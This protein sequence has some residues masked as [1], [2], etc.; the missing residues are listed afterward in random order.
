MAFGS[1]LSSAFVPTSS[2]TYISSPMSPTSAGIMLETVPFIP[3]GG[4]PFT[5]GSRDCTIY[6]NYV[7]KS[8][9]GS[10]VGMIGYDYGKKAL[11]ASCG[12]SSRRSPVAYL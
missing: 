7:V 9:G 8:P 6:N 2:P 1:R 5:M 4:V 11:V 12:D 10:Y 3:S